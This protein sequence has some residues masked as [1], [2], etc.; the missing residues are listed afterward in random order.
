MRWTCEAT[1]LRDKLACVTSRC[2]RLH[3]QNNIAPLM[4][5]SMVGATMVAHGVRHGR[6]VDGTARWFETIGFRKPKMQAQLS[7]A[8]EVASGAAIAVGFATP[9]AAASVVGTMTVAYATVHRPNG[10][11]TMNEGWST[12]D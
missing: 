2:V 6:T 5:R 9:F 11:F 3:R 7:S 8:L 10:F 12:S 1:D 4:L